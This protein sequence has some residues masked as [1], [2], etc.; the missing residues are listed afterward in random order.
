[1]TQDVPLNP[2]LCVPIFDA[3]EQ[4]GSDLWQLLENHHIKICF[5]ELI[6][7]V[8]KTEFTNDSFGIWHIKSNTKSV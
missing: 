5:L 8:V 7:K 4:R 2:I 3:N 1:M 6:T